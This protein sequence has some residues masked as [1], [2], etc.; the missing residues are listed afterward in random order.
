MMMRLCLTGPRRKISAEFVIFA[1]DLAACPYIRP[2]FRKKFLQLVGVSK[3]ISEEILS[4]MKHQRYMF[5]KWTGVD[6]TKEL[7]AKISQE[8]YS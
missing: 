2:S 1:L 7:N 5:T 4:Y 8:V 3:S 6:I